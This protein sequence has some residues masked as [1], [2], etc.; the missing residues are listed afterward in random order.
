MYVC[1]L[2]MF[3]FWCIPANFYLFYITDNLLTLNRMKSGNQAAKSH[4]LRD[5]TA[6]NH[7]KHYKQNQKSIITSMFTHKEFVLMTGAFSAEENT[8]IMQTCMIV[9]TYI[10]ITQ[11]EWNITPI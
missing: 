8:D 7:Q 3:V 11:K 5:M 2:Y 9:H 4:I 10:G 1:V 6:K